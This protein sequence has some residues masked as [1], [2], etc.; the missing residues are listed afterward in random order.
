M[1]G[2]T[3]SWRR[4]PPAS[5]WPRASSSQRVRCGMPPANSAVQRHARRPPAA[6]ERGRRRLD[7]PPALQQVQRPDLRPPGP[8]AGVRARLQRVT[9]TEADGSST[10]LASHWDGK[11]LNSPTTSSANRTARSTSPIR[12]M[13]AWTWSASSA[14]PSPRLSAASIASRTGRQARRCW[15]TTSRQPNGLCFSVDEKKLYR[16]RHR[17]QKPC[18]HVRRRSDDG[19]LAG[20]AVWAETKGTE[21]RSAPDGM[22]ID[23][24]GERSTP[25]ARAACISLRPDSIAS[26]RDLKTPENGRQ[27][28]LRRR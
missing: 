26:G 15:P 21:R 10:T 1:R 5:A 18:P 28:L 23:A 24:A 12:P 27:S 22:K 14:T 6:L 3:R 9:R 7:L 11:E 2:W 19:M 13:A 17:P 16:Q 20:G 25:A 4:T 8:P